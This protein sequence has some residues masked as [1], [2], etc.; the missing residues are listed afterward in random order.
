METFEELL[1]GM[2]E[3]AKYGSGKHWWLFPWD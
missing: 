2:V 1:S 3:A